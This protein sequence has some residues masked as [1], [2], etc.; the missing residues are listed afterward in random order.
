HQTHYPAGELRSSETILV[1]PWS[2][3]IDAYMRAADIFVSPSDSDGMSNAV[4]EAMAC[5]LAPI[6]SRVGATAELVRDQ[7]EGMLVEPLDEVTLKVAL[8]RA[9]ADRQLC[10]RLGA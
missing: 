5:G 3:R 8:E 4:L 7:Q 1:R 9:L 2:D 10:R 6:V